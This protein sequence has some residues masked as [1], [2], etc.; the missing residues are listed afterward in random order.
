ME[1]RDRLM[2]RLSLAF[3]LIVATTAIGSTR[4]SLTQGLPRPGSAVETWEI[5]TRA[6]EQEMGTSSWACLAV[7]R[8]DGSGG[9][10]RVDPSALLASMAGRPVVILVHGNGYDDPD[11]DEEAITIRDRLAGLGGLPEGTLFVI[12]D[13]PSERSLRSLVRDLGEKAPVEGRGVSPGEVPGGVA[14]GLDGLPD[15]PELRRADRPDDDA[16]A[17]RLRVEGVLWRARGAARL[18]QARPSAPLRSS[19]GRRRSPLARDPGERL[20]G[21]LTHCEAFLNLRNERDL[22]L[23][24]YVY[25]SFT[26]PKRPLGLLGLTQRNRRRL[27]PLADRVEDIEHHALSG[28]RHTL[29]PRALTYPCVARRIAAYTS[30]SDVSDGLGGQF[31]AR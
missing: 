23:S 2:T 6:C 24:V 3:A 30:F 29:F 31:K 18:G 21:A 22:A 11:S 8:Y 7:R 15:G 17:R 12:F 4:P 1:P 25:G 26:G 9:S 13:W 10:A 5:D 28:R 16:P 27:G 20:E 19:G 14:R